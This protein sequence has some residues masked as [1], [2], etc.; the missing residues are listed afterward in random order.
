[1]TSTQNAFTIVVV[2]VGA[3]AFMDL[4]LAALRRAGV[5]TLDFA[6]LGRWVGHLA[7][8]RIA[9]AAIKQSAPI[10]GEHTLGWLTHYLIGIAFAALLVAGAGSAWATAPTWRPALAFGLVSVLAP[11]LLM[12]PAMGLGIAAR[13]TPTPLRNVARSVVNHAVFGLGLFLAALLRLHWLA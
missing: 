1:M 2:G 7:R 9:H 4:W 8:G 11:L 6:L 3:T 13:K 5:P 12:Q 10:A